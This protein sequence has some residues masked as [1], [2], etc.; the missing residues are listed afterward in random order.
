[1]DGRIV[2]DL[3]NKFSDRGINCVIQCSRYISCH[4]FTITRKIRQKYLAVTTGGN[5]KSHVLVVLQIVEVY[6]IG[7]IP[8]IQDFLVKPTVRV[9]VDI[10]VKTF[11]HVKHHRRGLQRLYFI[12]HVGVGL[13][14]VEV[15]H[16]TSRIPQ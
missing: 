15:S 4:I 6:R 9:I 1:M 3:Y 12:V 5:G 8:T 14:Q 7:A 2:R 16:Q 10:Q 13:E 11:H